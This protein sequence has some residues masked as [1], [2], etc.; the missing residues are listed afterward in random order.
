M[1]TAML[2]LGIIGTLVLTAYGAEEEN[3]WE[4][5]AALAKDGT[6]RG[7]HELD[8]YLKSLTRDQ[9]LTAARQ[10]SAI[11]ERTVPREDW[12]VT[13]FNAIFPL[14]YYS[15]PGG[16]LSDESLDKL[17]V[18]I[19]DQEEGEY[20]RF[21]MA[22]AWA[23]KKLGLRRFGVAQVSFLLWGSIGLLGAQRECRV[24]FCL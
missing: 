9:M 20:F 2:F 6:A 4:T 1:K 22:L 11:V 16:G 23:V 12:A 8:A 7:K 3:Y 13:A 15:E 5:I 10:Y 19:A 21:A 18:I 14:A 17:V 24:E